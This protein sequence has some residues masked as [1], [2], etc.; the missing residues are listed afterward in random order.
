VLNLLLNEHDLATMIEDEALKVTSRQRAEGKQTVV[1]YRVED[2][3][4]SGLRE[5]GSFD[6]L[7]S[8]ITTLV[9]PES[10]QDVGGNGSVAANL[11]TGT[12]VIRQTQMV[13]AEIQQLFTALLK[14]KKSARTGAVSAPPI[15]VGVDELEGGRFSGFS[16][17]EYSGPLLDTPNSTGRPILPR[18]DA[19]LK[20]AEPPGTT[21]A[22][23]EAR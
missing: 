10:W 19:V 16:P 22:P 21:G 9:R 17:I 20:S 8:L 7:T 13:H 15:A 18:G 4:D 14:W 6:E 12:L 23:I 2:L 3:V 11:P 1:A 5:P